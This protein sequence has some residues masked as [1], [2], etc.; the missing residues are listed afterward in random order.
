MVPVLEIGQQGADS[1]E[2]TEAIGDADAVKS[3]GWDEEHQANHAD[4]VSVTTQTDREQLRSEELYT[5]LIGQWRSEMGHAVN[6]VGGASTQQKYGSQPGARYTPL[7]RR[8]S[9]KR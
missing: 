1:G 9:R 3:T 6:V 2:A 5:R 7:P 8:V 4:A